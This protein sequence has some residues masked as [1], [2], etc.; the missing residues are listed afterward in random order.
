MNEKINKKKNKNKL[1]CDI[2]GVVC[3]VQ[4]LQ[5]IFFFIHIICCVKH[6]QSE[7]DFLVSVSLWLF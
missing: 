6:F 4:N 5:R 3:R 7:F 2:F 1:G